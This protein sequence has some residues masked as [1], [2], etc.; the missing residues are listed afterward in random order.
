MNECRRTPN[1][2]GRENDRRRFVRRL[3]LRVGQAMVFDRR[4]MLRGCQ[5]VPR[6]AKRMDSTWERYCKPMPCPNVHSHI[7]RNA[8]TNRLARYSRG[9]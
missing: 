3:F 2:R 6:C 1:N 5:P 9:W 7:A 4:S 8:N